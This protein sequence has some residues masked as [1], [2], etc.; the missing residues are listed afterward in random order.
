MRRIKKAIRIPENELVFRMSRSSGPGGQNVNKVSSRVTVLFDVT[1]SSALTDT[2]KRRILDKLPTRANNDG[3]IRVV[4][5]RHRS[6]KANRTAAVE[7]LEELLTTALRTR[8]VRKKT[9]P[10]RAAMQRRLENKK[11]RSFLKQ[12]RTEK[13]DADRAN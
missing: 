9:V 6:Q 10:T 11:K 5:Q 12:Q 8:P 4:S 3:V 2:Q 1:N 7:R 13:F